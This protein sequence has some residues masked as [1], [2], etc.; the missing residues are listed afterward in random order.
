M[1]EVTTAP[2]AAPAP[3]AP[4]PADPT[5]GLGPS[6]ADLIKAYN[7]RQAA[8]QP[9]QDVTT[10]KTE[11]AAPPVQPAAPGGAETPPPAP[12][13]LEA[14]L[15][16]LAASASRDIQAQLEQKRA[17]QAKDA[18]LAA[19]KAELEAL[20]AGLRE[21]PLS[22]VSKEAGYDFEALARRAVGQG[23][24]ESVEVRRIREE[25]AQLKAAREAEAK[26]AQEAAVAR[27][28]AE[29]RDRW[30]AAII[31]ALEQK[32]ESFRHVL[33]MMEPDELRDAVSTVV[34]RVYDGSG[35]ARVLSVEE[36]AS[37]LEQQAQ[38]RLE[39]IRPLVQ[40][41]TQPAAGSPS[42]PTQ[43]VQAPRT[44]LTNQLTQATPTEIDPEDISDAAL[45]AR[46]IQFAR[47]RG[48]AK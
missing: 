31:P 1:P 24:P 2:T 43:P 35:G 44:G 32:R 13:A 36:A 41:V 6:D 47:A 10:P 38:Q 33:A 9:P 26:A 39:R 17:A 28:Q 29:L 25:V 15:A 45:T 40:P 27:Q 30:R 42:N 34:Q 11:A 8:A 21:D 5:D 20:R 4:P 3:A 16:E 37:L 18:E 19:V 46:A 22:V 14:R 23:T 7:D 48:L 12:V